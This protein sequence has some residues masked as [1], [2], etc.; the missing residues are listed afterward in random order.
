[1]SSKA[2]FRAVARPSMTNGGVLFR[3]LG[4]LPREFG[5]GEEVLLR[6]VTQDEMR[7][8]RQLK[9][10]FAAVVPPIIAAWRVEK[11]REYTKLQVHAA[12]MAAF[13]ERFE[14]D[15]IETPLGTIP[16]EYPSSRFK[17][18]AEFA[19]ITDDVRTWA[20]GRYKIH[21]PTPDEWNGED[22]A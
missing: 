11:G 14:W 3:P 5:T 10:W 7:T 22:A 8:E 17:S 4:N 9:Y 2:T 20:R 21:I 15:E 1:M 6:E 18:R 16:Q 19:R 13:T 12:L